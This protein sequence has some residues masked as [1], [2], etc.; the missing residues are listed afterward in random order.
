MNGHPILINKQKAAGLLGISIRTLEKLVRQRAIETVRIGDRVL[1]RRAD[2]A[3]FVKTATTWGGSVRIPIAD[4]V[5]L[6]GDSGAKSP[7]RA[8]P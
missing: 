2:L 1:F 3:M 8:K 5:K 4:V 6:A 7:S